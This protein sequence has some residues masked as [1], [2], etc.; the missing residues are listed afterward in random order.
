M[1]KDIYIKLN[2]S[3]CDY[4][5]EIECSII[6]VY[7][8][9][10]VQQKYHI[11]GSIKN[12]NELLLV[13]DDFENGLYVI[14]ELK[15]DS[16]KLNMVF[17]KKKGLT[18]FVGDTDYILDKDIYTKILLNRT[19]Y[20]N[21]LKVLSTKNPKNYAVFLFCKNLMVA[22]NV[23][24][25]DITVIPYKYLTRHD[26]LNFVQQYINENYNIKINIDYK[27][28]DKSI[29]TT[30]FAVSNIVADSGQ[31]AEE[32]ALSKAKLLKNL[33]S[34]LLN[35]HGEFFAVT[36]LNNTDKTSM[37]NLYDNRYKGNLLLY[38]DQGYNIYKYYLSLRND[39]KF[40]LCFS[41]YND[42]IKEND[43]FM[44]YYRFW[45]ILEIIAESKNFTSS[46][47]KKWDGTIVKNSGKELVIGDKS[48]DNVF[49]LFRSNFSKQTEE[50]FLND[51]RNI[52]K[53]K[54]FLNICYQRRCC[55]VHKGECNPNDIKICKNT[56]KHQLCKTN[57]ILDKNT[58]EDFQDSI[59]NKLM[60]CVSSILLNELQIIY[61]KPKLEDDL[62]IKMINNQKY[63][64]KINKTS[65]Q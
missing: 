27:L 43:R 3:Y 19:S 1:R 34:S 8:Y 20:F 42:A 56:N 63:S 53:V 25:D 24:Y 18:I 51:V 26:D 16:I 17:E 61:G 36:I 40:S 4:I 39:K 22:N 45:N 13:F 15:V 64:Y 28:F 65:Q 58:I 29:P 38:A 52:K 30:V 12:G 10:D 32:Y 37:T 21:R 11:N 5:G 7:N 48:V 31:K 2:A 41:M 54:D 6:R 14:T 59:L 9:F 60:F 62:I 33:Y 46:K 35:S 55:C 47:M 50:Q 44:K 23:T 57:N 49:E